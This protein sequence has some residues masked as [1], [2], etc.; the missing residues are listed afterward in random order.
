MQDFYTSE[1]LVLPK[2]INSL[3]F[4]EQLEEK[5][6]FVK[7]LLANYLSNKK[8]F[9]LSR[10][11]FFNLDYENFPIEEVRR[12]Q[13]EAEYSPSFNGQEKRV[14]ALLNFDSAATAAQNAALKIIEESPRDTLILLLVSKKEKVLETISSRCLTVQ[15]PSL[16]TAAELTSQSSILDNFTWPQNYSQAIDLAQANKDRSKAL[17]LVEELLNQ[18]SLTLAQKQALLGAYQDLERN[19]NVLLVL[20]NCFFSL[21]SLES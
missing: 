9:S 5:I 18:K 1:I 8:G 12:M 6:S 2:E 10:T 15:L 16:R 7:D 19:Q 20:E 4:E 21:V 14:F 17:N 3:R 11:S 13:T